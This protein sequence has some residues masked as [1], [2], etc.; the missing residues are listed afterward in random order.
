[1]KQGIVILLMLGVTGIIFSSGCVQQKESQAPQTG[2]S[3]WMD[4]QLKDVATRNNFKISDFTVSPKKTQIIKKV[5]RYWNILISVSPKKTQIIK[6]VTRYRNIL[7]LGYAL[8]NSYRANIKF[9]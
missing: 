8:R 9:T 6:K 5:T 7:I 2:K 4:I 3:A 1:M